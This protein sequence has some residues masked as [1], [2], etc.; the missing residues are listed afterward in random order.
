MYNMCNSDIYINSHLWY[1]IIRGC[2][3]SVQVIQ[4]LNNRKECRDCLLYSTDN[5]SEKISPKQQACVNRYIKKAY[6]RINLTVP[7]GDKFDIQVHA[8]SMNESVN[9][10]IYRA[11]AE[12]IIHDREKI[13]SRAREP[14]SFVE[15]PHD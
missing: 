1:N 3:G 10:F 11:I 9:A 4:L 8:E 6:D 13:Q 15:D 12:T 14:L 2:A 5:M 7:K